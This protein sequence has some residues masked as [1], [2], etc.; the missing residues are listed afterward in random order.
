MSTVAQTEWAVVPSGGFSALHKRVV[1]ALAGLGLA[2]LAVGDEVPPLTLLLLAVGFVVSWFVEPPRVPHAVFHGPRWVAVT[3]VVLGAFLVLQVIRWQLFGAGPL[4]LGLEMA[5]ALTISRLLS[6]RSAAEHQQIVLL[7][8]LELSASTALTDDLVWAVPFVGFLLVMPW[9]LALSHLRAEIE[10]HFGGE[11]EALERVLSSRRLVSGR[12]LLGTAALSVPMFAVMMGFFLLFPRVGLNFLGAQRESA[13][14][15]TGFGDEVHLGD[16]GVLRDDGT[17]VMRVVPPNLPEDPPPRAS[18]RMRGTS[19]DHYDGRSWGREIS[20]FAR[21]LNQTGPYHLLSRLPDPA[22]DVATE[23]ILSHLD[24]TVVFLPEGTVAIE[25]S[26]PPRSASFDLAHTL[27]DDVHY[28]DREGLGLRYRAWT[29]PRGVR[30]PPVGLRSRPEY[31]AIPPGHEDVIALA[32]AWTA[33]ATSDRERAERIFARLREGYGYTR[34]MHDPAERTPLSM[35]LFVTREGHCEYFASAMAV[36]LRAVSVPTRVVTG[37]LGGEWNDFGRYYA[38]RA[39]DSHAWV[40]AYLPGEGWVTF[41]PT[42]PSFGAEPTSWWESLRRTTG[43]VI[44][45]LS[46]AW[47][48]QIVYWDLRSQSDLWRG[49]F[50]WLRRRD[51]GGE[52]VDEEEAAA[53]A[54]PPR[55]A[56]AWLGWAAAVIVLLLSGALWWWRRPRASANLAAL[57]DRALAAR[58][59]PR[60][61]GRTFAEHARALAAEGFAF[62][63]LVHEVAAR[64]AAVRFGGE[65]LTPDELA[66]VREQI[67]RIARGPR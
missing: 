56:P 50:S 18:L 29:P 37:F 26:N 33:G 43:A 13:T 7:S 55:A 38:I 67:Q 63:E 35:F 25:L 39:S 60:P 1:Y 64:H 32:E 59:R 45:A 41:D 15:L 58:H 42:P 66:R 44:E 8:F 62:H 49:A 31:L 36:M 9:A 22:S 52:I 16:V 4:L 47:D 53:I 2:C 20:A 27:A 12:F 14:A 48:E 46:T 61:E 24:P 57:L 5:G 28:D 23:V 51:R 40:E 3:N 19:F 10:A 34:T 65:V 6:R 17:V 11:P 21:A 30:E 54:P